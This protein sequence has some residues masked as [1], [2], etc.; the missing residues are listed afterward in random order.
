[1]PEI[2]PGK[3]GLP[4][5]NKVIHTVLGFDFG[6]K[7]IGIAVGQTLTSSATPL[8]TLNNVN[9][10]P[11]WQR[12]EAL[13]NEWKP[14][15]LVV[16][17]PYLLDGKATEMTLRADKFSRRLHGRFGLPVFTVS[18]TLSSFEAEEQLKQTKKIDKQNKHEIDK[19]AAALITETWL[20]QQYDKN[21]QP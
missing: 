4:S 14:E 17:L 2:S 9:D 5:Q 16:G 15:A 8:Q 6:A 21:N 13:L 7:R 10:K 12:I 19:L 1:M 11:D 3:T 18:E 20:Q